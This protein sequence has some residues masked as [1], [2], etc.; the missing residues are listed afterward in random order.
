MHRDNHWDV[1]CEGAG[2]ALCAPRPANNEYRLE[3]APL[4]IS[5]LYLFRD[6][7][8]RGYCLLVFD[9]RH[10]TELAGLNDDEYATFMNDLQRALRAIQHALRPD[11]L[12]CESLGNSNPHLHWHIVP[13]YKDDPRWGQPIW[14]GWPRNEFTI[15]RVSLPDAEERSLI[16]RIQLTLKKESISL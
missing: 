13:R 5:T 3:I 4:T 1:A 9:A 14:E 6:Q 16:Q 15:H 2:C 12:N 10:A 11:H 8:F 7:R